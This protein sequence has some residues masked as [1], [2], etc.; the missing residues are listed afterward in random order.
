MVNAKLLIGSCMLAA[1]IWKLWIDPRWLAVVLEVAGAVLLS[2]L[3]FVCV[4]YLT[5]SRVRRNTQRAL[6]SSARAHV[7]GIRTHH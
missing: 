2:W 5:A 7:F 6:R 3:M 4:F 1:A